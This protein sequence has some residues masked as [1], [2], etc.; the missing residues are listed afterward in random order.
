MQCVNKSN[1]QYNK[2]NSKK[3]SRTIINN[4]ASMIV[5]GSRNTSRLNHH[6]NSFAS[7]GAKIWNSIPENLRKLPKHTFKIKIKNLLFSIL[8]NRIVMLT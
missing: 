2:L 6:K 8:I 3:L 1:E 7:I 5:E 4:Y